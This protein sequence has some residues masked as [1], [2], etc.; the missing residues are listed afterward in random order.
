M[1]VIKG[2]GCVDHYYDEETKVSWFLTDDKFHFSYVIYA[3]DGFHD[4]EDGL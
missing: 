1:K 3:R 4:G 2:A